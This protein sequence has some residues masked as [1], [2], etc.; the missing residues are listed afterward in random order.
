MAS[1]SM[2]ASD[3]LCQEGVSSGF[4]T[5]FLEYCRSVKNISEKDL[6]KTI[7]GNVFFP[8]LSGPHR[9]RTHSKH[10]HGVGIV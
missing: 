2:F 9:C 6:L 10:S 4:L 3:K 7:L 1:N 8:A 5:V